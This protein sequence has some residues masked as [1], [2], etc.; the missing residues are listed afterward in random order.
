MITHNIVRL[1]N[2]RIHP[3]H[4][5]NIL[6]GKEGQ[7]FIYYALTFVYLVPWFNH[8]HNEFTILPI[9]MLRGFD[10]TPT[11]VLQATLLR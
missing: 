6:K 3:F 1:G 10:Y 5:K 7:Y 11:H 2:N 4:D 8:C 9:R